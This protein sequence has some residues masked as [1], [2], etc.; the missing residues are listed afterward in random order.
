MQYVAGTPVAYGGRGGGMLEVVEVVTVVEG[1]DGLGGSGS[2]NG[3]S[4]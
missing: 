2:I 1:T 3:G 4:D